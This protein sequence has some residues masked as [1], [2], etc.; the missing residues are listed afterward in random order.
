MTRGAEALPD[1]LC[2]P[3]RPVRPIFAPALVGEAVAVP[4]QEVAARAVQGTATLRSHP[5][6]G[7]MNHGLS[8]PKLHAVHSRGTDS[9][10]SP[11]SP[12]AKPPPRWRKE[13]TKRSGRS[14]RATSA[15]PPMEPVALPACGQRRENE[16]PAFSSLSRWMFPYLEAL[17]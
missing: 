3:E 17:G 15:M 2:S 12:L 14:L 11:H 1:P 6:P 9:L 7:Q 10:R 13:R 5:A 16:R 8:P 4:V